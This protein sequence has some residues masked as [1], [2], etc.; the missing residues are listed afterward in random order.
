MPKN[1]LL[2]RR[3]VAANREQFAGERNGVDVDR[4]P[5]SHLAPCMLLAVARRAQRDRPLIVRLFTDADIPLAGRCHFDMSRL[6][7]NRVRANDAGQGADK[8]EVLFIV[9]PWVALP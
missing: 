7:A 4:P 5:E 2:P 3:I 8:S 6:R 1:D 9:S